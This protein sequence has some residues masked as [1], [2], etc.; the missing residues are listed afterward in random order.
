MT[1]VKVP[2]GRRV[3]YFHQ[4]FDDSSFTFEGLD[5]SNK[6]EN[7]KLEEMF[8]AVGYNRKDFLVYTFT[9]KDMN[10]VF[11]LS[12]DNEYP[13]NYTF[14]VVPDFYNP[15]L[16]MRMN[17]LGVRWFDDIV[18]SNRIKQNFV[19]DMSVLGDDGVKFLA[20]FDVV[21]KEDFQ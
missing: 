14:A 6:K 12:G 13:E 18:S 20:S 1:I 19:R 10:E 3:E 7:K 11:G 15:A 9:G 2:E 4:F 16:K 5:L 17:G 21:P 8:R